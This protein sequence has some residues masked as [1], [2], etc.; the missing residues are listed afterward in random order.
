MIEHIKDHRD[1]IL[2]LAMCLSL[3]EY[4]ITAV[5]VKRCG[6][7]IESN[8][9]LRW[10]IRRFGLVGLAGFWC[11]LWL[12]MWF[13]LEPGPYN[14]VFWLIFFAAILVN[15]VIVLRSLHAASA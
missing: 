15:N 14:S 1:T 4:W 12:V 9:V 13:W 6:P 2:L 10:V 11:A 3:A 7:D 5:C 8:V